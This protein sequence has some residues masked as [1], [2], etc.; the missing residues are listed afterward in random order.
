MD[1]IIFDKFFSLGEVYVGPQ[2]I[3]PSHDGNWLGRV[4]IVPTKYNVFMDKESYI[5]IREYN[6]VIDEKVFDLLKYISI[7][8][9]DFDKFINSYYLIE[10]ESSKMEHKPNISSFIRRGYL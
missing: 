8:K 1:R 9:S 7:K 10:W 3:S 6:N 2:I 4:R 5:G